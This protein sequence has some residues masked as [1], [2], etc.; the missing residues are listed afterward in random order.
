M[1]LR[2]IGTG[3]ADR[4]QF[5]RTPHVLHGSEPRWLP[6]LSTHEMASLLP[7][8]PSHEHSDAAFFVAQRGG[9]PIGRIGV[10]ERMR[11][12]SEPGRRT[13][14]FGWFA[15]END[16]NTARGLLAAAA[17]WARE[18]GADELI[19]P[20]GFLPSDGHG[21]LVEGFDLEPVLG[22][23]WN[24]PYYDGLIT[25]AGLVKATDYLSGRVPVPFSIPPEVHQLADAVAA[26]RGYELTRF[27][28]RRALRP[29]IR[30]LGHMYDTAMTDRWEHL[31]LTDAEIDTEASRLLPVSDPNLVMFLT[32]GTRVVGYVL[33]LPD[34]SGAVR[35]SRG[36]LLPFGWLRIARAVRT[37]RT[38]VIAAMGVDPDHRR[39]GANLVAFSTLARL[40]HEHRYRAAEIVQADEANRPMIKNLEL[41][42]VPLTK[43]HR[44]YRLDL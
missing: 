12:G 27:G 18:R 37:T 31:P 1:N 23:A 14:R 29:W 16:A 5:V 2:R 42:G 30:R 39:K 11:E 20:M 13:A 40:A 41:L 7:S 35:R 10:F 8:H 33:V 17:D 44:M 15:C 34:V 26:E 43:R 19:G 36:R 32:V 6:A 24:P 9:E 28:S 3:R 21:V 22:V 25:A 38:A 4:R